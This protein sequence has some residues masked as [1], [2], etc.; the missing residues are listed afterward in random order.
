MEEKMDISMIRK[1][2]VEEIHPKELAVLIDELLFEYNSMYARLQVLG[3]DGYYTLHEHTGAFLFYMRELRNAL[4]KIGELYPQE[5]PLELF[6]DEI[7][8]FSPVSAV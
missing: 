8:A 6:T 7:P 2:L 1:M 5:K 4:W 3:D